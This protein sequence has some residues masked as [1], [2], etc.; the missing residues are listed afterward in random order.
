[1]KDNVCK[2]QQRPFSRFLS[3]EVP[4]TQK[5]KHPTCSGLVR[6]ARNRDILRSCPTFS[7]PFFF[8]FPANREPD[9]DFFSLKP[10]SKG[11]HP[12]KFQVIRIRRFGGVREQTNKLTHWHPI[13]LYK[14]SIASFLNL[15]T[16]SIDN[17]TPG[18]FS[19]IIQATVELIWLL[20][21]MP[22]H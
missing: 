8:V 21:H 22:N 18:L 4:N 17:A 7:W 9:S 2:L 3:E 1:M 20:I 13:A 12:S 14:R 5:H 16:Y 19:I 15:D 11:N 6:A 10:P